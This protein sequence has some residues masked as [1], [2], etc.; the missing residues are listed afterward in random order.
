VV[1]V[2]VKSDAITDDVAWKFK[3]RELCWKLGKQWV[4]D[5]H[6]GFLLVLSRLLIG[7][8]ATVARLP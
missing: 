4:M 3:P 2:C 7:L 1:Q 6:E 5:S 8:Q